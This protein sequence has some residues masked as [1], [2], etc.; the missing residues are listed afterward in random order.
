MLEQSGD[1][2]YGNDPKWQ[3]YKKNVPVFVPFVGP[4]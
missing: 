2:K 1:K 3:Q 4:K